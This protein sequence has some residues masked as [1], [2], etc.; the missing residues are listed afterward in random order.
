MQSPR[1]R[2]TF[3]T[4]VRTF[5]PEE[6]T[7]R[8]ADAEV[9]PREAGLDARDVDAIWR[10]AVGVYASGLYPAVQLC[11]RRRGKVV[12]D[13]AIG[14]TLGNAP[15]DPPDA[16]KTQATPATL[17]N[18]FSAS[19]A[20]TAIL[21][22]LAD[23][24]H[25]IH[26]DDPVAHYLP[27]F[28][29]HGKHR[30][31]LRH[32][33]T[34]RAGIP[35]IPPEFADVA[36]LEHPEQILQILCDARPQLYPG[37]R[38]AYHALTG[39]FV[40][41][42]V[43]E[44]VTGKSMRALLRDQI[45]APLGF[46]AFNYGVPAARMPEVARNAFTGPPV[47]PP[48][49]GLIRRAL[50]VDFHDAVRMSNDPRFLQATVPAGNVIGTANE[51]SRFMQLLLDGGQLDGVR[52]LDARTVRRAVA[53]DSYL[54]VDLTLGLPI[55]YSMGFMLGARVGSLYGLGTSRAFGHLGFTNVIVYADP[56]RDIAVAIMT[57]GK[58]ALSP[59]L[60]RTL[61]LPQVI[62]RRCP[63]DWGQGRV[64]RGR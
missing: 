8:N 27:E 22:H 34:H 5:P 52:V 64:D 40:L 7:R 19:K 20:V 13:R 43:L 2:R 11:L 41:G 46:D 42:A 32:V 9:D 51:A 21:V 39:G 15:S 24:Q 6:V 60:V 31:T 62:A 57:S 28:G 61:W 16:H 47:V 59:G 1:L 23:Q 25:Q 44:R 58:P 55:R 30:I 4:L 10:A 29:R 38:L 56:Q 54:E 37:R 14:H 12:I 17:F 3:E 18:L 63:R 35:Q 53:E 48:L 33:L 45:L 26:L 50:S 36:L 49:A